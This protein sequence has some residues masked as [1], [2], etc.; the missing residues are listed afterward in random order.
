M[1]LI[2]LVESANHVCYRYRVAAFRKALAANGWTVDAIPIAESNRDRLLQLRQLPECDVMLVQRRLLP[3]WYCYALRQN[4]RRLVFDFDDAVFFRDSNSR[5]S[6]HSARR[7]NRFARIAKMCDGVIAGNQ[8]LAAK[9]AKIIPA[10]RV[11]MVPTCIETSRYG[12]SGHHRSDGATR[13]VWIGSRS[14]LASL[15]EARPHLTQATSAAGGLSLHTVCDTFPSWPAV[16]VVR[17]TWSAETESAEL[18]AGDIGVSW[19]PDHPWSLGKCGLKVLQYMASGLPVVANPIGMHQ[20]LVQFDRTG[21]LA[22]SPE[23]W[24][25]AI[26][27]LAANPTLRQ[28]MG[29]RAREVVERD[30]SVSRWSSEFVDILNQVAQDSPS[31]PLRRAA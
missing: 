9:A 7:L 20:Q 14:T 16:D 19:L 25:V 2:A 1:R 8:F 30:Y 23:D 18:A 31:E 13:L 11:H 27:R 28:D 3:L 29:A 4:T 10:N 21:L 22:A 26:R 24:T 6:P 12:M 15:E 17:R 5:K